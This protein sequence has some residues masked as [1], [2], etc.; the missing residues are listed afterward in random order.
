MGN[1]K[2]VY[3]LTNFS[4][5]LKSY[6]PIIVVGE[7][8]NMLK[9]NGYEPVL[10]ASASWN[11][12]ED[13]IFNQVQT[14]R[15]Y[16][17]IIDGTTVDEAF[18]REVDKIYE[19]INQTL[20][21]DS[22]V[23][24]HDLIFLPDYVKHNVACRRIAKE[25]PSIMWMHWIHSATSPNT[26][27]KERAMFGEQYSKHLNEKFPNSVVCFPNSYDIPRVAKNF[28]YEE[29]EVFEVPHPTNPVE[30]MQYI[31]K[32]LYDEKR[33][34]EKE[35]LMIYPLRLDRGKQ[36]E[37]N[38]KIIA[39]CKRRGMTAHV[40]F[41]DFQSTGDDK[42]VYR[43]ELK[44]LSK[45]LDCEECVTFVS[46]FDDASQMESSHQVVLDLFTLSN[47]FCLPSKSE[48]YSLV[49]QE[50][51]LRGNFCI[52]N[53]DF[54][55]MRQIYGKNAIYRQF[56]SNI[57]FGGFDGE[58]NTVHAPEEP[59]YDDIANN[60]KYWLENDKVLRAKTWVRVYRNPD[61]VFQ[62]FIEP[63]I[64]RRNEYNGEERKIPEAEVLGRGASVLGVG[65][66]TGRGFESTP[67][68]RQECPT[69]NQVN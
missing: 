31:V 30:G 6:S 3:I 18:E 60:L 26:L 19:E 27:I 54:M 52:L 46:E 67:L 9:R 49:A 17:P 43:E 28:G 57:A 56:S 55:P 15:I 45:E 7:Q 63:V 58:I 21:D 13:S 29:D 11:P 61:Y 33:L 34:W 23:F 66:V 44:K 50:A 51:M 8:I 64:S 39:A 2:Q 38:V 12:P 68:P 48:T 40:I 16:Q 41:C 10:V 36:A 69:G 25:R 1:N 4:A 22:V 42:V 59:W 5:Y 65:A 37:V 20:T 35:V 47:V 62:E 14:V 32:R 24:T 53:H